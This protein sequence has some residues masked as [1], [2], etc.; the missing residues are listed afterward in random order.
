MMSEFV[1]LLVKMEEDGVHSEEGSVALTLMAKQLERKDYVRAYLLGFN[2][3]EILD[4]GLYTISRQGLFEELNKKTV[5]HKKQ[6]KEARKQL[7]DK[8]NLYFGVER[9]EKTKD[10]STLELILKDAT[11]VV[12]YNWYLENG[13]TYEWLEN[14]YRPSSKYQAEFDFIDKYGSGKK[15]KEGRTDKEIRA[16]RTSYNRNRND[17]VKFDIFRGVTEEE[18]FK[19]RRVRESTY[20]KLVEDCKKEFN[21]L[22][23][24]YKNASNKK[25][26]IKFKL[27]MSEEVYNEWLATSDAN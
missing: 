25:Q 8:L 22:Q 26:I 7:Q 21:F 12:K 10:P 3:T 15:F 18:I 24:L 17:W 11:D 19:T 5:A 1:E 2:S 6:N 14:P 4:G 9:V 27:G 16:I 13:G 20:I 23:L